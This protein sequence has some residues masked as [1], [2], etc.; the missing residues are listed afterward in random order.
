MSDADAELLAEKRG[1]LGH[2]TLNRPR[3]IN[4]LTHAMIKR[5]AQTLVEWASDDDV[6]TVV[7][8]GAGERGLCAGGD[9]VAL[10]DAAKS[11]ELEPAARF[12]ADEYRLNA[13]IA[14]YPKPYVAIMDG[15][16]LGGG[17]GISAHGSHRVVTE[18]SS[19]GMPETGIGFVPDV[20]GSW[21]LSRA[22]GELGAYLA[23]TAKPMSGADAIATGFAD[24]FV[25]S[26][27]LP[28]LLEALET[29]TA[30]EA[31]A[32]VATEPPASDLLA[33]QDWIDEAFSADTVA[34]VV[35]RLRDVATE[36]SITAAETVS[37]KS[38]IALSV[39]FES[40]RRARE[41]ESLEHALEQEYRVSLHALQHRDFAEGVRAQVIEKDRRPKW[42]PDRVEDL[43]KDDID[44]FFEP[45]DDLRLGLVER[46]QQRG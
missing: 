19:V 45:V 40:L 37:I 13:Y 20:G 21:L 7:I 28:A 24:H 41:L 31:I 25:P 30:D 8:T 39:A 33:Q 32:A 16:T 17:V 27:Q 9:I 18:R 4:A 1:S 22:P 2:I 15:V 38:P 46:Q 42:K 26:D 35:K 43:S 12:W 5:V 11:H 3:A 44:K 6:Q 36:E 10:Y 29:T 23:L 34:N 14:G